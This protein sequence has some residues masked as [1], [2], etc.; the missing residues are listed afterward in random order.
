MSEGAPVTHQGLLDPAAPC[1]GVPASLRFAEPGRAS[2]RKIKLTGV[3]SLRDPMHSSRPDLR[4]ELT[5]AGA[6]LSTVDC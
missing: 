6:E 3:E 5:A 1:L 2:D 4:S